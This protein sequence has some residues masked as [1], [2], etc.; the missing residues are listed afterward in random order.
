MGR[1]QMTRV[2]GAT[3]W[4]GHEGEKGPQD[5]WLWGARGQ[6]PVR[7]LPPQGL[8]KPWPGAQPGSLNSNQKGKP[9]RAWLT[10][11]PR[12]L[13]VRQAEAQERPPQGPVGGSARAP[14]TKQLWEA[15]PGPVDS[16]AWAP[17]DLA[18]WFK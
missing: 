9:P 15:Y 14:E 12:P 13:G 2:V 4:P 5:P 8:P 3:R 7:G 10:P 18:G 1:N 16:L 6:R 17:L 11:R